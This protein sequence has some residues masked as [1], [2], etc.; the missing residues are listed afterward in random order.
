MSEKIM[1]AET[2]LN[3]NKAKI[4]LQINE[5]IIKSHKMKV[6]QTWWNI[7]PEVYWQIDRECFDLLYFIMLV[8]D[9]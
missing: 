9:R 7:S 3:Q 5:E 1:N 6:D 8:E 2:S 4:Q